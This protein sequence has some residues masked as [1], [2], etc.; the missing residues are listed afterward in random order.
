MQKSEMVSSWREVLIGTLR[1]FLPDRSSGR[2]MSAPLSMIAEWPLLPSATLGSAVRT[3]GIE[4]EVRARLP[5]PVRKYVKAETGRIALRMR[6]DDAESFEAASDKI[7]K[8]LETIEV[9]PVLPREVEDIL[10]ISSRERHKWL[11]DGR[12][13]SVGRR[14]VKMRARSKAV[15]FHVFDPKHIE[16]VLDRDLP[17]VWREEDAQEVAENRRRGA[18]KAALTR[19]GKGGD[20][21]RGSKNNRDGDLPRPQLKDWD[22]FDDEGLLR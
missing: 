15:T 10:T 8:T 14:T 3:K 5:W 1:Q 18:G 2:S 7:A 6:E 20:K 21:A 19:A 17:S 9:L 12:L 11:K 4:R 13:Q 16:D 22:A